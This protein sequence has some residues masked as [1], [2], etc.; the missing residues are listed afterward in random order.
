MESLNNPNH[1][2]GGV[3]GPDPLRNR[4]EARSNEELDGGSNPRTCATI[5]LADDEVFPP[6]RENTTRETEESVPRF[7]VVKRKEGD[8][9]NVSPFLI[10]KSLYG[11]LG[12]VKNV[13]KVKGELLIETR[14]SKQSKQFL[15]AKRLG[16]FEVKVEPHMAL[17]TSKGV[18]YC[19]DLL[20]CTIEEIMENLQSQG[21]IGGRR[22]RTKRDGEFHDTPNHILTFNVP[23]LP[24]SIMAAFYTLQVRPYI[25]NPLRCFNCQRFGH[26]ATNCKQEKRCVCGKSPHEGTLCEIPVECPNCKGPHKAI[27]KSCEVY[28]QEMK[29]Q[30]VKILHKLSYPEAKKKVDTLVVPSMSFAQIT[31]ASPSNHS[32]TVPEIR[33]IIQEEMKS[34]MK[35]LTTKIEQLSRHASGLHKSK[36]ISQVSETSIQFLEPTTASEVET[37]DVETRGSK[38][39]MSLARTRSSSITSVDSQTVQEAKQQKKKKG[40]PKGKPRMPRKTAGDPQIFSQ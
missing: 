31:A 35:V 4:Q 33:K 25:P 16:E 40:W 36:P 14:T 38:R 39:R 20:N 7:L 19:K 26:S 8:F 1:S 9:N 15:K 6:M 13:K 2:G 37:M 28:K 24:K 34:C 10:S 12:E 22:I 29:I 3:S 23:R 27:A 32:N 17:N 30:E 5:T 11:L 21:V 18:V